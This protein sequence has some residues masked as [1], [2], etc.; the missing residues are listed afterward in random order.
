MNMKFWGGWF[1]A[2]AAI[3]IILTMGCEKGALGV[4]PALVTG[5]I[6]DDDSGNGIANATVRMISKE[7][8]GT[9][10]V[11]QGNNYATTITNGAGN[12]VFENVVPDNVVF[13]YFANNYNQAVFPMKTA[14]TDSQGN[15]AEITDVDSVFVKSGSV[16]NI[17]D[18]KLKTL[19]TSP[20]AATIKVKLDLRD[21]VSK[22][23][24]PTTID[25]EISLNGLVISGLNTM[26]WRTIG[27]EIPS[28][29]SLKVVIRDVS[30]KMLYLAKTVNIPVE[31]DVVEIIELSP[32]T[33]NIHLRAVNVP[34]YIRGGVVNIFA[35]RAPIGGMPPKVLAR[36]TI[37]DLGTLT[38][39]NLP[40]LIEVPGL[41]EPVDVRIQVRGYED[42]VLKIDPN[43]L[44]AGSQ[45][46][47]RIDI[48][49][50]ADNGA[51]F[52]NYDPD[53]PANRIAALFDN[54]KRRSIAL[55][56]S[57]EDLKADNT[58]MGFINLPFDRSIS[59]ISDS[60]TADGQTASLLFADVAV[61]YDLYYTV[62]VA[63]NASGS[64]NVANEKGIMISPEIESTPT[65]LVIGVNAKRPSS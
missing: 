16:T 9:G 31:G 30:T 41:Q 54:M 37:N 39:P 38:G 25:F 13:E 6:V 8:Y 63:G 26:S 48:D 27:Q 32:V 64:F 50:L 5:K 1:F 12:F 56:V 57:G 45:G 15:E 29:R 28:T 17:G 65:T 61:G 24:I 40:A 62:S 34:D 60:T 23:E 47:Y 35:E 44:P 20:L 36:Q 7:K 19:A 22:E 11:Q 10:E 53:V 59:T 14:K 46:N 33:Y 49:F 58:V 21:S 43:N 51:Y 3:S 2:I 55:A 18:L 4:K 52:V 42:E